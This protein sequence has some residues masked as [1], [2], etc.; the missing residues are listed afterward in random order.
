MNPTEIGAYKGRK[1]YQGEDINAIIKAE[2]A[3]TP[4]ING[5]VPTVDAS[6]VGTTKPLDIPNVK[7]NRKT[8]NAMA[9]IQATAPAGETQTKSSFGDIVSQSLANIK[10]PEQKAMV[11]QLLDA[12]D[13][14]TGGKFSQAGED[15]L[16][17]LLDT[18]FSQKKRKSEEARLQEQAGLPELFAEQGLIES[19]YDTSEAARNSRLLNETGGK[20]TI[21]KTA[22]SNRQS[23]IQRQYGLQVADNRINELV[24]AG[25]INSANILIERKLDL[26]YGD[27]EAEIDLYKSQLEA[28]TPFMNKEQAQLA[29]KRQFLLTQATNEIQSARDSEKQLE[30]TK[31][32][33]LKNAY[34]RGASPLQIAQIQDARSL[35]DIAATGFTT[36]REEQ[37][38]NQLLSSQLTTEGL[39]QA[40]L[41]G[42][43]TPAT[44]ELGQAQAAGKISETGKLIQSK[45]L[46]SAVGT[47][48]FSRGAGGFKGVIGRFLAGAGAGAA[49]GAA[50]GSLLGGIGAIPGAII[51][52]VAG[53]VITS[54]Q[55]VK[56]TVT[57]ERQD[58]IAGVEQLR[59]GLNLDT[60][61]NAKARGAT[62]GALSNQELQVLSSS[63]TQLG[64]W[65]ITNKDGKVIGYNASEKSV[66]AELNKINNYAK[67]DAI[68]KGAD[69]SSVGVTITEDGAYWAQNSDGSLTKIR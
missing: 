4:K 59:S 30:L 69:P 50:G 52:A 34:D 10:D 63:A 41:R 45:G 6:K 39:Q 29:E 19:N 17:K 58:F 33:A 44:S 1:I 66:R 9:T 57:G 37:L 14:T 48:I 55:G 24:V 13:N 12:V 32:T 49:A 20:T 23:E 53:G 60:L 15:V 3:K 56:D 22:L 35:A 38:R 47:T 27:L 2:D 25:K 65:A 8:D 54:A 68:L 26:K 42:E 51:G 64:T 18:Q 21:S 61:I 31:A 46:D 7:N 16:S 62:F 43:L 11:Q 5:G 67:L 36:T 28:I 40:K